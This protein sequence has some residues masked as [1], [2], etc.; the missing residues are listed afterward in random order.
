MGEHAMRWQAMKGSSFRGMFLTLA[1]TLACAASALA[2]TAPTPADTSEKA[3]DPKA[4]DSSDSV[5]KA[6]PAPAK[7]AVSTQEA[8]RQAKIV[9]DTDKLCQL[10]QE[11]KVEVAKSSKDT[12]SLS[13]IKKAAEIEKLAKS[14]KE[15]MRPQ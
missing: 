5:A 2:Q 12:L 13:V 8:E 11:L 6:P 7:A 9:A 15:R 10:I 1:M 4:P 3:P 14:L